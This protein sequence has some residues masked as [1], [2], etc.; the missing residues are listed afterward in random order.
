SDAG[1]QAATDA[2]Q[3]AADALAAFPDSKAVMGALCRL[4]SALLTLDAHIVPAHKHRVQLKMRQVAMAASEAAALQLHFEISPTVPEIGS[5][6]EARLS[7]HVADT[8]NAPRLSATLQGSGQL[9]CGAFSDTGDA[10]RRR[11]M[12][13][14]LTISAPPID[15]MA[16]WHGIMAGPASLHAEVCLHVGDSQFVLPLCPDTIFSTKPRQTG[17]IAPARTL[18]RLGEDTGFDM[19]LLPDATV[20]AAEDAK[21]SLPDGWQ[22]EAAPAASSTGMSGRVTLASDARAG[23]YRIHATLADEPVYTAQELAYA[24]IRRQTRFSRAAADIALVDTAGLDGLTIGWIDGGVDEA[25]HWAGQLGAQIVQLDDSD[26]QS[27]SFD[28]LDVLVAG[29][30]A[31]GTRPVNQ[32]MRYIRPWIEAGGHFVSQYHRPVDNW[33]RATSSPLPLQP[34]TPSIRWRV[35]DAS[36]PVQMLQPDHPLFAGPNPITDKDFG[37]WIKERGLYFASE[38]DQ[39]YVPLLA[40]SDSGE[41]PLEGSLLAAEIGAGSHVHCALNLFYQMDHMVVGAFRLFANLL[42]PFNGK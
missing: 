5:T 2:Q 32:S 38:W 3:A 28:G 10:G 11:A 30:F 14:P 33:D 4:Q 20:P 19:Q 39:A 26:L 31:G 40:M 9:D 25:H 34:G 29:V 6:A 16:G 15:A 22:F 12:T 35:T 41:K 27:G 21:L 42:T 24:H 23:H 8:A 18:L 1:P 7:W 36:A 37:G 13:A 17:H